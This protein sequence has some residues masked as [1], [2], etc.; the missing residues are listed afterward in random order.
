MKRLTILIC[1][2]MLS[3]LAAAQ[4]AVT[5]KHMDTISIPLPVKPYNYI[6]SKCENVDLKIKFVFNQ[7]DE[8]ITAIISRS[9]NTNT[10]LTYNFVFIP[11]KELSLKS[12][13]KLNKQFKEEYHQQ[14]SYGKQFRRQIKETGIDKIT[15][16]LC[17]GCTIDTCFSMDKVRYVNPLLVNEIFPLSSI[18]LV[19]KFNV[20]NKSSNPKITL[21]NFIPVKGTIG[22][23]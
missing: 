18:N 20:I 16:I 12:K 3:F 21:A 22:T 17:E 23:L 1:F 14:L 4:T 11:K 5:L 19:L 6:D 15:P 10:D 8:T 9:N 2:Y 13:R 7:I